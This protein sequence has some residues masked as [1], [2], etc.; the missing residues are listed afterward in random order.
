L[1]SLFSPACA[2]LTKPQLGVTGVWEK[3]VADLP[4]GRRVVLNVLDHVE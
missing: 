1:G 3:Y 2:T 4:Q